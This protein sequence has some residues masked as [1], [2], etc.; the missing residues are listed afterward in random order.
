M[1]G[2]IYYIYSLFYLSE[3]VP[4]LP[5]YLDNLANF[6]A[7]SSVQFTTI[8]DL[9]GPFGEFDG[10]PVY[11][12]KML[13]AALLPLLRTLTT[14]ARRYQTFKCLI[15][16]NATIQKAKLLY[17]RYFQFLQCQGSWCIW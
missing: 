3:S 9:I 16:T 2:C 4:L 17:I 5:I 1:S 13:P 6:M 12:R 14:S 10:D 15:G 7:C 8:G 11:L